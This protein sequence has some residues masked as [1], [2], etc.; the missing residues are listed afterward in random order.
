MRNF[1]SNKIMD[2]KTLEELDTKNKLL[3]ELYPMP[4]LPVIQ[5]KKPSKFGRFIGA[6]TFTLG[7]VIMVPTVIYFVGCGIQNSLLYFGIS[8]NTSYS[9]L[10]CFKHGVLFF[11]LLVSLIC[12]TGQLMDASDVIEK[13]D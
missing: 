1:L 3:D 12:L 11:A 7:I 8:T 2:T 6:F 5:K 4:D 10:D 9:G 13:L